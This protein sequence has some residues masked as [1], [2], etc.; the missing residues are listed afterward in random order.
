M[1][2]RLSEIKEKKYLEVLII[3]QCKVLFLGSVNEILKCLKYDQTNK[4]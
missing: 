4:R 3:E 1:A 2:H